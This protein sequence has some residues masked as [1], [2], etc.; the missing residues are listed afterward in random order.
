[1]KTSEKRQRYKLGESEEIFK[2]AKRWVHHIVILGYLCA[3]RLYA[4]RTHWPYFTVLP[5]HGSA[6]RAPSAATAAAA[7]A[8]LNE[9]IARCTSS[10]WSRLKSRLESRKRRKENAIVSVLR[11]RD[12][13]RMRAKCCY[14]SIRRGSRR[15]VRQTNILIFNHRSVR[16]FGRSFAKMN[17]VSLSP[18]TC[19]DTKTAN[20]EH[21]R[22]TTKW[23]KKNEEKSKSKCHT[24]R[25]E[26]MKN[27][28]VA[29]ES[30]EF[31]PANIFSN[32]SRAST[33]W[34]RINGFEC[35]GKLCF[36]FKVRDR[37]E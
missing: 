8:A 1:M 27:H 20:R 12:I 23:K 4:R 19:S 7:A 22:R 36:H 24:V 6:D 17:A 25:H 13:L 16:S 28:D 34:T 37:H 18:L 5:P 33:L 9:F 2:C 3:I 15:L 32:I 35:A 11:L 21:E 30:D 31:A 14:C 10:K 26:F 29:R